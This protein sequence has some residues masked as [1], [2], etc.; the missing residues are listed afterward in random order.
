MDLS[1]IPLFRALSQKL[2]FLED[3]QRV[4]AQ[5]IANADTPDYQPRDLKAPDFGKLAAS[6]FGKLQPVATDPQHFAH[7]AGSP[8][9]FRSEADKS[10]YESTISGNSVS[11]EQELIKV[12]Q[13]TLDHQT[14][15]DLYRKQVGL[16]KT[17]LDRG[18][19]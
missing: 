2:G 14:M 18:G 12:S 11:L 13:T 16:L 7:G 17:A 3:R 5:N 4:L 6:E 9:E 1:Q 8:G 19:S 15:V 10:A